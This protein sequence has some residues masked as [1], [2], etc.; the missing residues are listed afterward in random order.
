M[1]D[2][3]ADI[4]QA[5][6]EVLE[7]IATVLE[8]RAADAQQKAMLQAYLAEVPFPPGAQVLEVGCGTGA[9]TR[10]LSSQPNV[11]RA[12]GLDPSELL[13]ERAR[14]LGRGISNLEFV[15]GDGRSIP[16]PDGT[17]DIVLLHT[18]LCHV[19]EPLKLLAEAQRVLK[20]TGYLVIFDADYASTTFA[21][22]PHDPLQACAD[23]VI[24]TIAHDPWLVRKLPGL[25]A[26][27]G[28]GIH[29]SRGYRYQS[30]A[31]PDYLLTLVDR[32]AEAL[33]LSGS[34]DQETEASLK[35]EARK[36]V[37]QGRFFAAV[38]YSSVI[39]HPRS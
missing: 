9:V 27:A 13:L 22:G 23:A 35:L 16:F 10:E 24:S 38:S 15:Q 31:S 32:G 17:L 29:K 12:I 33:G 2:V 28:F 3:Y 20:A 5:E 18:T 37:E 11:A 36:R 8:L 7:R 39:A 34:I 25:L 26:A 1:A 19:P 14:E 21:S 6:S 30:W 4:T